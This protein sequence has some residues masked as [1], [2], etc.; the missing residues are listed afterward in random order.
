MLTNPQGQFGVHSVAFYNRATGVPITYMRVLGETT[1]DFTAEFTDL[2]GG[3]NLYLWDSEVSAINSEVSMTAREYEP[4]AMALF[5]GG[6]LT[7]NSTELTGSVEEFATVKGTSVV[8]ATVGIASVG[9]TSGDSADLK[10]GKYLVKV[11]SADTFDVYAMSDVDFKNGT[12]TT[13]EDDTLKINDTVLDISSGNATL[14]DYGLE[15]VKG[16][17]TIAMTIGDTAEFYVRKVNSSSIELVFGE[18]GSEFTE[19]GVILTGQKQADGTISYLEI[20][21]ARVAGMPISFNEKAFSEFS[22][23]IKTLYDSDRNA[24]GKFRRTKV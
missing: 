7:E 23:T 9:V 19:V 21:K 17:G 12:D 13:Y 2:M 5:L 18:A 8:S 3:S 6:T 24:V 22:V 15:F 16:S 10:E 4:N 11:V 14:A 1:V 20:Y